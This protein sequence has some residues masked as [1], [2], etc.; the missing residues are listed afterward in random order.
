M[1]FWSSQPRLFP[2]RATDH[3]GP[4]DAASIHRAFLDWTKP[5]LSTAATWLLDHV[6][7]PNAS[8]SSRSGAARVLDLQHLICVLPGARAGKLFLIQLLDQC[9]ARGVSP[10]PPRVLTPGSM[11]DAILRPDG[12]L[13]KEAEI[14]FAWTE[15]LGHAQPHSAKALLPN[16]PAADD[17]IAWHAL[18]QTIATLH[19]ELAGQR[20]TFGDAAQHADRMGFISE[21]DRWRAMEQVHRSYLRALQ[22]A[23]LVDP[24]AARE[25][26]LRVFASSTHAPEVAGVVLIGNVDLN[27]VQ[28]AAVTM[29]A[30]R[31]AVL[32]LAPSGGEFADHFDDLGCVKPD[33]WETHPIALKESQIIRAERPEDQ[34]RAAMQAIASLEGRYAAQQITIGLGDES[35]APGL[36]RA[37]RW[38]GLFAHD[39][40]GTSI[41]RS[42]PA[43]FLDAAADWLTRR[44]FADLATLLRHPDVESAV[45]RY[46]GEHAAV[47]DWL[48]L[49]DRYFSDHLHAKVTGD[50][51][52]NSETQ[53]RLKLVHDAV[54]N[55]LAPLNGPKPGAKRT[56]GDRAQPI[57][58]VLAALF[59]PDADDPRARAASVDACRAIAEALQ[60]IAQCPAELQP[61]A[62]A[63]TAL[64]LVLSHI[65]G[66][67]IPADIQ[68]DQIEMLG[69]LEVALDPAPVLIIT[70]FNDGL[71][72]Q[73]ISPD[74]FLPDSLRS[75]MGLSCN[76]RRYARDAYLLSSITAS[77]ESLTIITGRRTARGEPL[78]PSR[79]LLACDDATLVRRVK[80]ICG[81]HAPNSDLLPLGTGGL[82]APQTQF[83]VPPLPLPLTI[84]TAMSVTAFRM[85]LACPYRFALQHLLKLEA[86]EDTATELDPLAFGV[87]AHDVLSELGK[88]GDV[89]NSTEPLAIEKFLI[90]RAD[91]LARQRFGTEPIPAV[92]LQMARLHQRLIAFSR[93]QAQ[94]RA[95]GWVIAECEKKFEQNNALDIPGQE[96]MVIRGKIDRIDRH[97]HTGE[98]RILDYKTGESGQSPH[99]SHHDR[100]KLDVDPLEWSDLQLP[101]YH[102][103][104]AHNNFSGTLKLGYI[105]L[106]KRADGAELKLAEWSDA[107][108]QSGIERAR[109]VVRDIREQKFDPSPDYHNEF[110]AFA[111]ICQTQA[112][113]DEEDDE[114]EA[115]G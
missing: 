96:A 22:S 92:L 55:L 91:R 14:V 113:S 54:K 112:F 5:A 24:H 10:I 66:Q 71:I 2:N 6:D 84:P 104:A 34:C 3:N 101:L 8:A 18:A 52:G 111:R 57:L 59:I 97:E 45:R 30:D 23:G 35:L 56:I 103:L 108:V 114:G 46:A 86:I 58:G 47:E 12:A 32:V 60:Q 89:A 87:L 94:L 107:Q 109:Q 4:A 106:P 64:R 36:Q 83:K 40:A 110:D 75:A 65:S 78:A 31:L 115:A 70:G 51:L 27:A 76:A 100:E 72:P 63:P 39:P 9:Q 80:L 98:W 33:K 61:S 62:D 28:R 74:G 48:S 38:A 13:A 37:A 21:G 41:G 93:L 69:W 20:Q 85:Y 11:V 15:S 105:V 17:V 43:R 1:A 102:Q 42:A 90:S 67:S 49:L 79:L 50:W 26:S 82:P 88:D 73:T 25:S 99:K 95:E 53:Q 77:R 68:S 19:A 44:R 7:A 81:E 29:L 16:P